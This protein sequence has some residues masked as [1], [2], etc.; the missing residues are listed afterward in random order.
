MAPLPG[1]LCPQH[2]P[3]WEHPC[4][5]ITR[6]RSL[7]RGRK[8]LPR[9]LTRG[10]SVVF[11]VC[12]SGHLGRVWDAPH[13]NLL[14]VKVR[15]SCELAGAPTKPCTGRVVRLASATGPQTPKRDSPAPCSTRMLGCHHAGLR[16]GVLAAWPGAPCP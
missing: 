2:S 14:R 16:N 7:C 11:G 12:T 15:T 13:P 1:Q 10:L 8:A 3:A 6:G 5:T 9:V 4:V